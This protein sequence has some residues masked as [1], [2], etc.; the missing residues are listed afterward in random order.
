MFC[1]KCNHDKPPEEF[2]KQRGGHF[3]WCKACRKDYD[4]DY[5]K[6][7]KRKRA[8]QRKKIRERN[9]RFIIQFLSD[10]P[11]ETC[12]ENDIRVLEFAH[13][14]P[15]TKRFNVSDAA[16]RLSYS[17]RSI[18]DE[19]AKCRILCANCHRRETAEERGYYRNTNWV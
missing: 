3:P 5:N 12:K 1:T 17:I 8:S 7:N 11:C 15:S 2:H 19:I 10:K 6:R 13:K 14:D 9:K 16:T 18:E 4:C